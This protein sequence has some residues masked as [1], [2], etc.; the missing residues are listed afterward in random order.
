MPFRTGVPRTTHQ[1]L[2]P[3]YNYLDNGAQ[4]VYPSGASGI[5]NAVLVGAQVPMLALG[6][7]SGSIGMYGGTGAAGGQL[8]TGTAGIT[9]VTGAAGNTGPS[10]WWFNGGTGNWYT[11]SDIVTAL[12]RVNV[13]K[14]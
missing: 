8:S 1:W 13:L 6:N 3:L 14:P 7:A 4:V 11:I 2:K 10:V 5:P 12:K 9:G